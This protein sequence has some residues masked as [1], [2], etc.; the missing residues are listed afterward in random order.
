MIMIC[1]NSHTGFSIGKSYEFIEYEIFFE[2][3][4]DNKTICLIPK[5]VVSKDFKELKEVR[6]IKIE[7]IL[8]H[9]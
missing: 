8:E 3:K 2:C 7:E 5:V 9:E 1:V 4:N 6:N